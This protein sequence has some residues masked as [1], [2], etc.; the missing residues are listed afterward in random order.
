M[1]PDNELKRDMDILTSNISINREYKEPIEKY[2][3]KGEKIIHEMPTTPQKPVEKPAIENIITLQ[4][5]LI[6]I[7]NQRK[8]LINKLNLLTDGKYDMSTID[9]MEKIEEELE[10]LRGYYSTIH[11]QI[12][13]I[14][15]EHDVK[16]IP[17]I[18]LLE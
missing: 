1:L 15:N 3:E 14:M 7:N 13:V 10:F 6:N 8:P 18:N 9:E 4:G 2:N 17:E 5:Q 11:N 16:N 12:V